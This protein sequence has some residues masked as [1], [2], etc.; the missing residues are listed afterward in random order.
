MKSQNEKKQLECLKNQEGD[1]D[2]KIRKEKEFLRVEQD[3]KG[4]KIEELQFTYENKIKILDKDSKKLEEK[5]IKCDQERNVLLEELAKVEN[6]LKIS[7]LKHDIVARDIE[8][9]QDR[10]DKAKRKQ[11]EEAERREQSALRKKEKPRQN[12]APRK[13]KKEKKGQSSKKKAKGKKN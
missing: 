3:I 1:L 2:D 12:S 8:K 11:E 4:R 5:K 9:E 10:Q 7:I 6:T 13:K